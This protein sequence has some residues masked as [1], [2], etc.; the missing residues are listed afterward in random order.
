MLYEIYVN[1]EA[2]K[3]LTTQRLVTAMLNM[4]DSKYHKMAA[5]ML[6]VINACSPK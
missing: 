3:G 6:S 5:K 1:S 2:E 4:A